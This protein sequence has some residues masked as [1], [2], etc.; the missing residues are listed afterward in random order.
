MSSAR[1]A[2][3]RQEIGLPGRLEAL[4]RRVER[5]LGIVA[6][7]DGRGAGPGQ[8]G[9]A[10]VRH[11]IVAVGDGERVHG[12]FR[13]GDLLR[14]G[15]GEQRGQH[16]L[17]V[18]HLR[19]RLRQRRGVAG[20][21]HGGEQFAA[22]HHRSLLRMHRRDPAAGVERRLHLADVHVA[23]QGQGGGSGWPLAMPGDP[24]A[25]GQREHDHDGEDE[26]G[27]FRHG[28]VWSV[29]PVAGAAAGW[30]RGRSAP[31]PET[32]PP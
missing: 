21:V 12:R 29:V 31:A 8:G 3:H 18:A 14:A 32:S 23:V 24:A 11:L 19:L 28:G 1:G 4:P 27:P 22:G 13:L 20:R 16:L 10:P 9:I 26:A 25:A 7:L 15:A 17:L 5:G 2:L 6:L 30:D